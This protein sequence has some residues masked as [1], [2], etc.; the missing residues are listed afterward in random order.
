MVL[1]LHALDSYTLTSYVLRDWEAKIDFASKS[2]L[3]EVEVFLRDLRN[4]CRKQ[5]SVT[6][7][8]DGL[9]GLSVGPIRAFVSGSCSIQDLDV[10]IQV[11]FDEK[12]Y[13]SSSWREHFY[14]LNEDAFI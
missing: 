7:F 9:D 12:T 13:G 2:E 1:R 4:H 3:G 5:D 11:F 14:H 8:F 6:P 10:V